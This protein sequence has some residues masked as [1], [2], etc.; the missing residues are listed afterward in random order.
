MPVVTRP[1]YLAPTF[2]N[3]R[4]MWATRRKPIEAERSGQISLYWVRQSRAINRKAHHDGE[5]FNYR[6]SAGGGFRQQL[7]RLVL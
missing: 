2:P 6:L 5:L 7:P 1:D 4:E 3:R